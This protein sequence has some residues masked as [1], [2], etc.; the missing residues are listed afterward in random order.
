MVSSI[1][2]G[3]RSTT[4]GFVVKKRPLPFQ[5]L[6][7]LQKL[8]NLQHLQN[9]QNLQKTKKLPK[10]SKMLYNLEPLPTTD[11]PTIIDGRNKSFFRTGSEKGLFGCSRRSRRMIVSGGGTGFVGCRRWGFVGR[12]RRGW[13][14]RDGF[15]TIRQR[16]SDACGINGTDGIDGTGGIGGIGE[17]TPKSLT[18][19]KR[20]A[21]TVSA[22][23]E[24]DL[25]PDNARGRKASYQGEGRR[26]F[27]NLLDG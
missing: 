8:Q 20:R 6:Q 21:R 17:L 26:F 22:T 13:V 18:K 4:N 27:L 7:N 24:S 1:H 25:L 14:E 5:D 12:Q 16:R 9:L 10:F 3:T 11:L 19:R 2:L 15:R 23:Q